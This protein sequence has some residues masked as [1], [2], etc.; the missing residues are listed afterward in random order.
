[1]VLRGLRGCSIHPHGVAVPPA[2][3]GTENDATPALEECDG[4]AERNMGTASPTQV[5]LGRR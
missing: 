1:M 2:M 4:S 5:D 3:S